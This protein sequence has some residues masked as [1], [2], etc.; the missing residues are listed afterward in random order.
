MITY[1]QR[2]LAEAENR[3]SV[4]SEAGDLPAWTAAELDVKNYKELIG[5][6]PS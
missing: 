5:N 4:A 2:K 6:Q 1:Y 3:M